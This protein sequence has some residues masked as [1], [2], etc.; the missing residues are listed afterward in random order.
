VAE[1]ITYGLVASSL[2]IAILPQE[3]RLFINPRSS[4]YRLMPLTPV[5]T[6][7][8]EVLTCVTVPLSLWLYI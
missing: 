4:R 1:A 6:L 3:R 7:D 5:L 2:S 8:W